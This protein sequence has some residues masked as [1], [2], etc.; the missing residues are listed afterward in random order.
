MVRASSVGLSAKVASA[1]SLSAGSGSPI[2]V[3]AAFDSRHLEKTSSILK[4]VLLVVYFYP[5]LSCSS[6]CVLWQTDVLQNSAAESK[7]LQQRR[8]SANWASE[9]WVGLGEFSRQGTSVD[10]R[11]CLQL[12]ALAAGDGRL[13]YSYKRAPQCYIRNLQGELNWGRIK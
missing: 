11:S 4:D 10:K 1:R 5:D 2:Q 12:S 3:E 9:C 7:W 8:A 13:S 6:M